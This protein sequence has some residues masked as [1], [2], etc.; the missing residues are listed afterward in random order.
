MTTLS[1][2]TAPTTESSVWDSL[3]LAIAD[4]SGF[5]CWQDDCLDPEIDNE[6]NIAPQLLDIQV[7]CYLRQTLET[8]AY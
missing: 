1:S 7:R 5:K 2:P 8:L 6:A 4:S 3:K